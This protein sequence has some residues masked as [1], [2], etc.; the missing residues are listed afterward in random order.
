MDGAIFWQR[1]DTVKAMKSS[2]FCI[3]PSLGLHSW[4]QTPRKNQGFA[5]GAVMIELQAIWL[6]NSIIYISSLSR[7]PPKAQNAIFF[8]EKCKMEGPM[9]PLREQ[10]AG[11][12]AQAANTGNAK[13]FL[14]KGRKPDCQKTFRRC[15][16]GRSPSDFSSCKPALPASRV[17]DFAFKIN[18]LQ[19]RATSG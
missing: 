17:V 13:K 9:H 2:S 16:R 12:E 3:F 1:C 8:F 14:R 10:R 19:I 4:P 6:A 7:N 18:S 15:R 11:K 5:G